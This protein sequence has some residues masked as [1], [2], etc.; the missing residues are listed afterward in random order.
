MTRTIDIAPTW[1][2]L[3]PA[4]IAALQNGT[5]DGQRIAAEELARLAAAVDSANAKA[6]Q[7]G[8]PKAAATVQ[9]TRAQVAQELANAGGDM[10]MSGHKERAAVALQLAAQVAPGGH[11]IARAWQAQSDSLFGELAAN[12]AAGRADSTLEARARQEAAQELARISE[13]LKATPE[14]RTGL[15]LARRLARI[16]LLAAR[17]A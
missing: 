11:E 12:K 14:A 7:E 16:E 17:L 10:L 8:A 5:G 4:L 1:A 15:S 6:R 9:I 13:E 2:A 3:M